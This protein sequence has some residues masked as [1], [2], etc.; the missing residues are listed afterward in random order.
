[1]LNEPGVTTKFPCHDGWLATGAGYIVDLETWAEA[2]GLRRGDRLVSL[3]GVAVAETGDWDHALE[4]VKPG[5]EL[6][7]RV[8]RSDRVLTIKLPCKDYTP[9]WQ[10]QRAIYEAMGKGDWDGCLRAAGDTITLTGRAYS[11]LLEAQLACWEEKLKEKAPDRRPYSWQ[12]PFRRRPK[13]ERPE[14]YWLLMYRRYTHAVQE[15]RFRPAGVAAIRSEVMAAIEK[16]R[17]TGLEDYADDLRQQ[18]L[19]AT[20]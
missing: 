16:L 6:V 12:D 3:G 14:R 7:V 13:V 11:M 17:D 2:T 10:V 8:E 1:M 9:L 15:A 4:R 19:A 18:L 20:R 5:K